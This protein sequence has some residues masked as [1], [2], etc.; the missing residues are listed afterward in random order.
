MAKKYKINE[1]LFN[2]IFS[3]SSPQQA[4]IM[5]NKIY[6]V[7]EEKDVAIVEPEE[8]SESTVDDFFSVRNTL[9]II[10]LK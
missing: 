10:N 8:I 9:K 5:R 7:I 4:E 6:S 3:P 1:E 2:Q